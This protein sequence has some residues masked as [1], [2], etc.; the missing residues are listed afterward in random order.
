MSCTAVARG[1]DKALRLQAISR[2]LFHAAYDLPTDETFFAVPGVNPESAAGPPGCAWGG[3]S[4]STSRGGPSSFFKVR[5]ALAPAMRATS[6]SIRL[7]CSFILVFC[8][9]T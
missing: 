3:S 8:C 1:D 6:T 5:A 7:H 2:A 9:W 4:S